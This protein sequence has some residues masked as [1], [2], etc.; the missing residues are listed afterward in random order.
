MAGT[1]RRGK[2]RV[3]FKSNR[4]AADTWPNTP[5]GE[6]AF[7]LTR[8]AYAEAAKRHPAAARRLLPSFGWNTE[9]FGA[10]M[11]EVEVLVAWDL[12]T[13]DL[14][15][16]APKL[17]WIHVI[18]AGVE[19]LM[20]MGWLPSGVRLTNNKGVH[21]AKAGEYGLMTLLMLNASMP[22]LY[23]HQRA[24]RF[25]QI[26]ATPIAGKTVLVVGVGSIG[27]AV[28]RQAKRAGL[29]V[30]GVS[31]HGRK[32]AGVDRM[33]RTRDIDKAL[34]QAD[35]LF[36]ATPLTAETRNLLD[37]RRLDL[38]KPSAGLVNVGREPV[39]DYAALARKLRA[40]T[41]AGAILDVFD[42]EPLPPG[43]PLWDA[44]NLIVTPHVSSDDGASYI[45]LT[46]DLFFANMAR[47]LAGKPLK[48]RVDAKLGY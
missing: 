26:Y 2:V 36:V 11:R 47:Y 22:A 16:R 4:W 33:Y 27:G 13:G 45:P 38:L 40:G 17:K 1:A 7:S 35:Y 15:R 31:R 46:L 10:A 43:S 39:V 6:A 21:A 41:L 5:E 3:H 42:P 28:A 9:D 18:G 44:P 25:E 8:A 23:T 37:A 14:A 34:P 29:R 12:P 48:N 24:R 20:P 32:T 19:H 30:L